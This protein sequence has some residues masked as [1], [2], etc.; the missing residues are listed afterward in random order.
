M[1]IVSITSIQVATAHAAQSPL[2]GAVALDEHD[3]FE[4]DVRDGLATTALKEPPRGRVLRSLAT[5]RGAR[6]VC[7]NESV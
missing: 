1:C 2:Q 5:E 6:V 3:A 7:V 4:V